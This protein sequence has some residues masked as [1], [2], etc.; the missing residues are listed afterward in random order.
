MESDG[1][2]SI[3]LRWHQACAHVVQS[4]FTAA[5]GKPIFRNNLFQKLATFDERL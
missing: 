4:T 2:F 1:L 3:Y 5:Y